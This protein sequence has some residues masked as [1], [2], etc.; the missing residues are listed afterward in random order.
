MCGASRALGASWAKWPTQGWGWPLA[1]ALLLG[2]LGPLGP[3][4][5]P[6]VGAGHLHVRCFSGSWGL[7][8]QVANPRLGLATCM[9]VAS[10]ALGASWAKWP[11]QG[12]GWPLACALLLGLLG[13]LGPSGQPKVGAGHLHVRCFSGSWGLLGQV[14]S[15]RLGL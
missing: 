7:L 4:G 14:A 2:L 6:K 1:C 13:P 5:Q 12:W 9:C 3:S 10:R 15:P 11:T 8:G